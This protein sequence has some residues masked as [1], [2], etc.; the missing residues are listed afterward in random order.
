MNSVPDIRITEERERVTDIS[1]AL[2]RMADMLRQPWLHDEVLGAL[3]AGCTHEIRLITKRK[4]NG[5]VVA[6]QRGTKEQLGHN[7]WIRLEE[8]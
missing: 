8:T 6:L 3:N 2:H 5:C 7:S 4:D 1:G